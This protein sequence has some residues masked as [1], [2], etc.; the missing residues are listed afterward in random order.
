MWVPHP[1]GA[2]LFQTYIRNCIRSA[3]DV[4]VTARLGKNKPCPKKQYEISRGNFLGLA[5][6]R[7][8]CS[9]AQPH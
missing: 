9:G 6:S 1:S 4:D 2:L 7:P 3:G 8:T 5:A